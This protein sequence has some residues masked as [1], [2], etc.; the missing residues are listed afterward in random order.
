MR[1]LIY[2]LL[3]LQL[4][5]TVDAFAPL[6]KPL[7]FTASP[8]SNN[9]MQLSAVAALQ[10]FPNP[11]KK[12]PWNVQ[13]ERERQ[14]RRFKQE[15][16]K[17][18]RQL[19]IA[20]DATYEEIVEATDRLMAANA[21]DLKNKVKIEIAKDRILQL[22]LNERMAGLAQVDVEARMQSTFEIEG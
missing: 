10:N 6:A 7:H 8:R 17:L 4:A 3:I 2:T 13:K 20:E 19:G 15:R 11:F 22:R 9:H 5:A 18:H 1:P 14:A 21:D 12:L 16:A